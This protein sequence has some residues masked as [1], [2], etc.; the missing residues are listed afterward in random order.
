M[1]AD[2]VERSRPLIASPFSGAQVIAMSPALLEATDALRRFL[3]ERVY[4]PI[5]RQPTTRHAET[6][7]QALFSHYVDH[8]EALPAVIAPA[9]EGE[10]V[11]R[12]VADIVCG[13]TDR[14]AIRCYNDLFM[15]RSE[16][17]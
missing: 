13:M 17:L 1:V 5:N 7:V 10:A 15:P 4:E 9:L 14:Y 2:I 6:I 16:E 3:F 8:P 12:R 11:E